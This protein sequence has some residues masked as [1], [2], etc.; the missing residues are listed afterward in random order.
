VLIV[1]EGPYQFFLLLGVGKILLFKGEKKIS[2]NG[3]AP[4]IFGGRKSE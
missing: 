2:R 4:P 1:F 3:E